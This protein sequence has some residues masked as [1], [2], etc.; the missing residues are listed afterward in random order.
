MTV[1][2]V[3]PSVTAIGTNGNDHECQE[4]PSC[5]RFRPI[6][7]SRSVQCYSDP[8]P[9]PEGGSNDT[10][11]IHDEI[12][13]EITAIAEEMAAAAHSSS[14]SNS[15][16]SGASTEEDSAPWTHE[17]LELVFIQS[18][19][20]SS[21]EILENLGG[22]NQDSDVEFAVWYLDDQSNALD[23]ISAVLSRYDEISAVH[24]VRRS[25]PIQSRWEPINGPSGVYER[26]RSDRRLKQH[27]S[28]DATLYL[29]GTNL[30]TV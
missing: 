26:I 24:L 13:S 22:A 6:G 30:S 28:N 16:I 3:K 17:R 29:H 4:T 9:V 12:L 19:Y 11:S 15:A 1:E 18:P 7:K 27:L 2:T 21:D 23:Q 14:V 8:W 20:A 10:P 5:P 25:I